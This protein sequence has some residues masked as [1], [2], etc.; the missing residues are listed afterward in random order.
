M[1][2]E[3]SGLDA[4]DDELEEGV[5]D[6]DDE[7]DVG[8]PIP[9]PDSLVSPAMMQN[10]NQHIQSPSDLDSNSV[11]LRMRPLPVRYHSQPQMEEPPFT[12]SSCF[13]RGVGVSFQPQSPN[14]HDPIRRPFASTG[15]QG[16]HQS[17]YGWPNNGMAS[18]GPVSSN[19]YVTT[20][21]QSSLAPQSGPYQLPPPNAQQGMLP[22]PLGQ[23]H[24]DGLPS[25]RQ[26][27]SGPALGNQLRTG[28]LGH[29]HHM[30]QHGY[31]EYIHDNGGYGQNDSELKSDQHNPS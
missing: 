27:D 10:Q 24:Y 21:P 14:I 3:R 31:Q 9:T 23:H 8:A 30:P 6:E 17:I 5:K 22:S 20:S 16:P 18:S 12:D 19:Y 29:P 4:S 15:Y 1:Y 11:F 2:G 13:P 25:V 7:H 28:S 26:Y